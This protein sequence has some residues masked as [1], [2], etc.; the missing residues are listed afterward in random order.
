[1]DSVTESYET[2]SFDNSYDAS[3]YGEG[4]G[5][6]AQ[7]VEVQPLDIAGTDKEDASKHDFDFSFDDQHE[8]T[9]RH[10]GTM[11]AQPNEINW[12]SVEGKLP[13]MSVPARER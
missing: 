13:C 10:F 4:C 1:M 3:D 8:Y 11:A 7:P 5:Y 2:G 12:G 9:W 6:S